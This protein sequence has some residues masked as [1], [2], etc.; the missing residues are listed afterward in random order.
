[1]L[2]E[3]PRATSIAIR[4]GGSPIARVVWLPDRRMAIDRGIVVASLALALNACAPDAVIGADPPTDGGSVTVIADAALD[5]DAGLTPIP[6]PWSTSFENGV[7]G[8]GDYMA[9]QSF[10]Y[11][12]T[13]AGT[14]NQVGAPSPVHSGSHSLSF[15]VVTDGGEAQARCILSG[16]LPQAAYYGAWYFIPATATNLGNWNLIHFQGSTGPSGPVQQLWDVSLA[17]DSSGALRLS[18]YDFVN[19]ETPDA[20]AVPPIPINTWFH[21]GV[22]WVRDADAGGRFAVYQNDAAVFDLSGIKTD[23]TAWGQFFVGNLATSLSPSSETLYVDDVSVGSS[24]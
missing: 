13:P 8:T 22:Y 23:T 2:E 16:V 6:F 11:E 18:A 19:T 10:C 15:T 24:L 9:A 1:V 5:G 14:Y 4:A 3:R 21:I 7:E 12:I 20:A 17:N